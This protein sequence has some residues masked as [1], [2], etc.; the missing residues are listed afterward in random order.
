MKGSNECPACHQIDY[1]LVTFGSLHEK[2]LE[3][4]TNVLDLGKHRSSF[5]ILQEYLNLLC[6]RAVLPVVA[7]NNCQ[8][9]VKLCFGL[10]GNMVKLP[11]KD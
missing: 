9:V 3:C 5:P 10:Q 11:L 8:E 2:Y 4:M 7:F 6:Q 1:D